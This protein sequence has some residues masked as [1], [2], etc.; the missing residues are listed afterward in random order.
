[1]T[2][3]SEYDN[4]LQ[5]TKNSV[6]T[7]QSIANSMSGFNDAC[8]IILPSY[9]THG[10]RT[11]SIGIGQA[12]K[13]VADVLGEN[14]TLITV[15]EVPDLVHV[16]K[17][18]HESMQ[19]HHWISIKQLSTRIGDNNGGRS[20][21]HS[22]FGALVQTKYQ[23]KLRHTITKVQYTYCP[24]CN[25]T[26]KDYGGKKNNYHRDGT[27]I[28]DVWRDIQYDLNGD[29]EKLVNRFIDLFSIYLYEE[30]RVLDCRSMTIKRSRI[31]SLE[32]RYMLSSLPNKNNK[33][34]FFMATV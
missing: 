1:M 30:F 29:L 28:S 27:L 33:V 15:G 24:T 16:H 3:I 32:K 4:R 5:L 25:K 10:H 23:G 9:E 7:P 19:F 2:H 12:V 11:Q 31:V 14:A 6:V 21:P 13:R 22:H 8:M 17:E 20:L 34:C 18:L 26:T